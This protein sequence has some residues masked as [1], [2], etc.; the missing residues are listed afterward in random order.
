MWQVHKELGGLPMP[1]TQFETPFNIQ[2]AEDL[3]V[4]LEL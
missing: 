2:E 1:V 3:E 4:T